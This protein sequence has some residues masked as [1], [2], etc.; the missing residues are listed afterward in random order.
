[1]HD[2]SSYSFVRT[3]LDRWRHLKLK[4]YEYLKL[5]SVDLFCRL[6]LHCENI[7]MKFS[8]NEQDLFCP[9]DEWGLRVPMLMR[10]Q[11][12]KSTRKVMFSLNMRDAQFLQ[13]FFIE[14]HSL[15]AKL[16]CSDCN[17]R[18]GCVATRIY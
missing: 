6:L 4:R 9:T 3:H 15:D 1:M 7:N 8:R 14:Q 12:H 11:H 5:L 16:Q 13:L 18:I 17:V 2:S 10:V